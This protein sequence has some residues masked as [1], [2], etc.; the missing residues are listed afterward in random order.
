[1]STNRKRMAVEMKNIFINRLV[2]TP[3]K[4]SN[5][6]A[7]LTTKMQLSMTPVKTAIPSFSPIAKNPK[8]IISK[9]PEAKSVLLTTLPS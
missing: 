9:T 6:H 7:L 1:M 5:T 8:E 2:F 3:R 4:V